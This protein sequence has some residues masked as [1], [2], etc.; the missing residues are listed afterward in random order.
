M[1]ITLPLATRSCAWPSLA[2]LLL[3]LSS[4]A[5]R[6]LQVSLFAPPRAESFTASWSSSKRTFHL[7]IPPDISRATDTAEDLGLTLKRRLA[8]SLARRSNGNRKF[9]V[10][11]I[12]SPWIEAVRPISRQSDGKRP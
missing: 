2:E 9:Q 1:P 8:Y 10:T 3:A 5:P 4:P 11:G 6:P 12:K 7:L